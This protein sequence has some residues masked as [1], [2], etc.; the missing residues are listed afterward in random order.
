MSS[1]LDTFGGAASTSVSFAAFARQGRKVFDFD[2]SGEVAAAAGFGAAGGGGAGLFMLGLPC[3]GE[4]LTSFG[5]WLGAM[6]VCGE[7]D[8]E[9]ESGDRQTGRSAP[10]STD[11][12]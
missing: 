10:G 5:R 2:F 9:D 1:L 3:L 6:H 11:P 7:E 8:V 4:G 12:D